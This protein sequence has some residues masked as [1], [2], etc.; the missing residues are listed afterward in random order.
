MAC[1]ADPGPGPG[2]VDGGGANDASADAASELPPGVTLR[3]G[4]LQLDCDGNGTCET[5]RDERNCGGCGLSCAAGLA[6]LDGR[7]L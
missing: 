3:C 6:C 5:T 1:G 2:T 4:A 7:C